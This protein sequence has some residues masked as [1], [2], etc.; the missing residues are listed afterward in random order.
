MFMPLTERWTSAA[1]TTTEVR[2]EIRKGNQKISRISSDL[3]TGYP[4]F[5]ANPRHFHSKCW[6]CTKWRVT[7]TT[8]QFVKRNE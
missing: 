7:R 8:R 6:N 5:E 2:R 3:T 4:A 1:K